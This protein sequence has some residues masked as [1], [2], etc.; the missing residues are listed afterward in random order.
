MIAQEREF[1]GKD[2]TRYTLRSPR[3]ADAEDML[4]YLKTVAGETEFMVSYP[5]ELDMNA[6]DEEKFLERLAADEGGMMLSAF[7]NGTL[8]GNASLSRFSERRK[9]RHRATAGIALVRSAWGNGLGRELLT[10]LI[11]FAREAGYIQ[12]ELEVSAGNFRALPLYE[13]LGFTVYGRCPRSF[14][15][16]SG[17]YADE[18]LMVLDLTK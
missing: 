6:E 14:K 2:G 13:S 16:D 8:V 1:V 3:A 10:S 15:L 4:E 18:F 5:D 12:V 7:E 9:G 17:G 11:S